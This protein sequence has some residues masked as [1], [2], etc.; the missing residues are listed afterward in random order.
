MFVNVNKSYKG[1]VVLSY[2]YSIWLQLFVNVEINHTY[3]SYLFLYIFLIK[4]DY[5]KFLWLSL[6]LCQHMESPGHIELITTTHMI[7]FCYYYRTVGLGLHVFNQRDTKIIW[8]IILS[9]LIYLYYS[10]TCL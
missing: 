2:L 3:E 4:Y 10:E 1:Y 7:S 5:I 8:K 6:H 9:W